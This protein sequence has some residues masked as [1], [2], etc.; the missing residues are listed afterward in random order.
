[1]AE[2]THT[3]RV[4]APPSVCVRVS[5]DAGG[6]RGLWNGITGRPK[7]NLPEPV[8][9]LRVS[10]VRGNVLA[11]AWEQSYQLLYDV[12]TLDIYHREPR[13]WETDTFSCLFF[14]ARW[15]KWDKHR[16]HTSDISQGSGDF[17]CFPE[18][19]V[20]QIRVGDHFETLNCLFLL[21][22]YESWDQIDASVCYYFIASYRFKEY[23]HVSD[24]IIAICS[25]ISA[26]N[27]FKGV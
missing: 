21:L 20:N 15:T 16:L 9:S 14:C 2:H 18:V 11:A 26:V 24:R 3:L 27:D 13:D 25:C 10:R 12:L 4:S 1:M 17:R 8:A 19:L 22:I 7:P 23:I 5:V 6:A